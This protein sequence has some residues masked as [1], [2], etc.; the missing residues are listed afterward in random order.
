MPYDDYIAEKAGEIADLAKIYYSARRHT[1]YR[2]GAEEIYSR[3][4]NDLTNRIRQRL[5]AIDYENGNTQQ[6]FPADR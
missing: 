2:G 1:K 6:P 4:V 3:I 5:N